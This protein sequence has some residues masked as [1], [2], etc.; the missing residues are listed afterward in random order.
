MPLDAHAQAVLA[1][2]ADLPPLDPATLTIEHYRAFLAVGMVPGEPEPLAQVSDLVAQGAAGAIAARAYHPGGNG[3]LPV[4]AFFHGGGFVSLGLDSHDALCRRLALLSG[5]LVV[6]FD[7]RLAPE[8]PFPAA[9][10]DAVAAVRW[11]H[12]HAAALGGDP[13]RIAVAGDS[14]GGN[15]AAVAAQQ[16]RGDAAEPCHQLLLYPAVDGAADTASYHEHVNVGFLPAALMRW[17]WQLYLGDADAHDPLASPLR[18]AKLAG[19]APATVFTAECDPLRDEG[20]AYARALAATGNAVE[21]KRW[22]GQFHGFASL[23]GVLPA[24]DAAVAEGA[25]ALRR[26][27]AAVPA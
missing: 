3:P 25:A 1:A 15:L 19:L 2:F 10:H 20:E 13:G 22:D 11:L 4:V 8:A 14:A 24:A 7:Y 21:L 26:A 27:F 18:S 5:A 9:A 23:L 17:F 6:S 16:L 12:A